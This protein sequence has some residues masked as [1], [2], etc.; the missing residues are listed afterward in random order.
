MPK[1]PEGRLVK[2]IQQML[3]RKG[4][5]GFKIHGGDNYQERGIPDILCCYCGKFVGI[6][7]KQPGEPLSAAQKYQL[8]RIEEAGGIAIVAESLEDVERALSKAARIGG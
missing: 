7:C 4:A 6:E 3:A 2:R 8:H 5:V 1:Q